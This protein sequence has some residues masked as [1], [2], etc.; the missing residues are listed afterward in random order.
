H[1]PTPSLLLALTLAV[2]LMLPGTNVS[3]RQSAFD[4]A[5]ID[6]FVTGQ[7]ED[8]NIP[9]VAVTI[10]EGGQIIYS[11]GFGSAGDGREVTPQTLFP[12]GSLTKSMTA[13]AIMQFAE[14][15]AID[16]EAPV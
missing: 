14:A 15:G 13:L 1:F 7:M 9:G 8:S 10:V 2:S 16:L 11:R 4:T 3:A 12:I 6:S 5:E